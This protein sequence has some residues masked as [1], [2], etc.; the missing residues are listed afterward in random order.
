MDKI[1]RWGLMG[2][3]GIVDRWIKG[4]RQLD[5]MRIVAVAS[6]TTH[7]AIETAERYNIPKS[8]SY[9][10]LAAFEDVDIVYIPVPHVAHKELAI[11]AMS[12]GKSVLV[13]KPAA[14]NAAEWQEMVNCAKKNGVFLMEAMW[15]RFFPLLDTLRL[16]LN[17]N[18]IGEIRML[19]VAFSFCIPGSFRKGRLFDPG[20]A[21]GALLDLGV[22]SLTFCDIVMGKT[23]VSLTGYAD[24]ESY[25]DLFT[26][27]VQEVVIAKYDKGELASMKNGFRTQIPDTACIF[28]TEGHIEIPVFWKPTIMYVTRNGIK[29]EYRQAI[30]LNHPEYEDEGFQY[31]IAHANECLRKG[32]YCSNV[33]HWNKTLQIL[34]QCDI[35]RRQWDFKYPFE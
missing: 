17:E 7:S 11:L 20:Q 1:I 14:V 13:E 15:T 35:L 18:T 28:G 32:I 33:M 16:L 6:R 21:G 30:Q 25:E 8:M 22:Y 12:H 5:D 2:A 31:E 27:D 29:K 26:V 10:E 24:F 3:G 4:A 19:D 34:K 9:E 23:P